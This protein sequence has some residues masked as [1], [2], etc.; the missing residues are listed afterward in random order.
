MKQDK[1]ETGHDE[2]LAL[3]PKE[4]VARAMGTTNPV[5]EDIHESTPEKPENIDKQPEDKPESEPPEGD[6]PDLKGPDGEHG[7]KDDG[8]AK[9]VDPILS[10]ARE[11]GLGEYKTV[12]EFL[13]SQKQLRTRLSQRDDE[14]AFGRLVKD[15]GITPDQ[16]EKFQPK[17]TGDQKPATQ[18]KGFSPPV[19][20]NQAWDR[21]VKPK[22]DEEGKLVGYDGPPDMVRDYLTFHDYQENY[23]RDVMRDPRKIAEA[24]DPVI[25]SKVAERERARNE[26]AAR[27]EAQKEAEQ[28]LSK[29]GEFIAKHE[30]RFMGLVQRGMDP[31]LALEHLKLSEE[32]ETLR[33][34]KDEGEAA[35]KRDLAE[36][37]NRSTRRSGVTASPIRERKGPKTERQILQE[38]MER[39]SE[40]DKAGL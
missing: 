24:L 19:P 16:I 32:A 22:H 28:F 3:D 7:G 29:H 25:E 40:E 33:K 12:D 8:A 9:V 37:A 27:R 31:E 23:W 20:F 26:E 1:T 36:A 11:L 4:L 13:A 21:L 14:A 30:E 18:A 35:K 10:R 6:K 38:A 34:I 2:E 17:E 39:F 5:D 15:R